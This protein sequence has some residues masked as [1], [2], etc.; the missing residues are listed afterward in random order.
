MTRPISYPFKTKPYT[1]QEKEFKLYK[2]FESRAL[3]WQ[4]RTGKTKAMID[5]ACY[6][7][8]R[9]EIDAVIV[10]APNNV[11]LNWH[12]RE[13]G[14]HHWLSVPY[15]SFVWKA[16][17]AKTLEFEKGFLAIRKETKK[18][19][20]YMV[21]TEGMAHN[22]ARDY[23]SLFARS[24]W[25]IL[26]I[27]DEIHEFRWATSKRSAGLRALAERVAYKRILSAN[28]I[29]NSPLHAFAEFEILDKGALG[30]KKFSEF[31]ARYAVKGPIYVP[32]GYRSD[33][34]KKAARKQE[35]VV[36]FTNQAE[37]RTRI[38]YWSS[39]VMRADCEDLPKLIRGQAV[40]ELSDVQ[41]KLHNALVS[42][43]LA[44]LDSGEIIPPAEGGVLTIRLQQIASGFIVGAEGEIVEL[45]N[46]PNNPRMITLL[47]CLREVPGKFI[48]WCKFREDVVRVTK[49]LKDNGYPSVHYYGGT[50]PKQRVL[51]EEQFR[52]NPEIK[53]LVGQFQ[54]GGQGLD[55]SEAEDIFWYSHT[56]D[57]LRRKQAD[58]RATKIGGKSIA[59]TDIVGLGTGDEKML[60]ALEAKNVTA[61][62]LTGY[63]LR[64]YLNLIR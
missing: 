52:N 10:V 13:L 26:L 61:D 38:A 59:V 57:L 11:H 60:L 23:I 12:R 17:E 41:K 51:H 63:G 1:H 56:S 30:F 33:G 34:T 29:D 62:Y 43:T 47:E 54:A 8:T 3:I 55:F 6:L 7:W 28:P 64:A 19:C 20:W 36:G 14:I 42:E 22:I 48:V 31:E 35:T 21:N 15:S 18:L 27:V 40:F 32:G 46:Q 37:L 2:D 49:M 24:K 39:L 16:S 44:R 53:G 50:T 9:C 58:E 4:M 45:V 5:L 25:R